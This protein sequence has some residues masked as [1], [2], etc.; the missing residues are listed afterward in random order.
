MEKLLESLKALL[1]HGNKDEV[2]QLIEKE[3]A[4]LFQSIFQ[5][6]FDNGYG[7]KAGELETANAKVTDLQ[8]K[9]TAQDGEIAK[10]KANP[11]TAA[12]HAQYGQEIAKVKADAEARERELRA[13]LETER[14]TM[15][16]RDLRA[17]LTTGEKR[18]DADYADVLLEKPDVKSRVKINADGTFQILQ[19]GKDIP[20]AAQTPEAALAIMADELK[21]EAPPRFVLV[22]TDTG[23]GL[24]TGGRSGFSAGAPTGG[25]ALA[26]S[27]R[28]SV[29]AAGAAAPEAPKPRGAFA[30]LAGN[31]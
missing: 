18:L 6:G 1:A 20:I 3:G 21:A 24:D 22:G 19:K 4:P 27:I 31:A 25:A 8:A 13:T 12:L 14:K 17:L 26:E 28:A 11:D 29:K 2:V 5:R 9:V 23:G 30:G 15:R 16:T 7:K 10:L